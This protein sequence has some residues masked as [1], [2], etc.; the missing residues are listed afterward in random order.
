MTQFG[1][2]TIDNISDRYGVEED[3]WSLPLL[4]HCHA[5][6]YRLVEKAHLPMDPE[7]LGL[8]I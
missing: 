4:C 8:K 6:T 1:M 2:Q 3:P 5:P 7:T